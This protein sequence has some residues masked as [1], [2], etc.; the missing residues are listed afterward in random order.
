MHLIDRKRIRA[1]ID[2][3]ETSTTGHIAVRILPHL[4]SDPV[5]NAK[6]Q[7][8]EARLHHHPH[9]NSVVFVVAPQTRQ[10]AVYGDEAVHRKV[11]DEY[12]SRLVGAMTGRFKSGNLTDALVDGIEHVGEQLR[13]HFPKTESV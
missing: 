1:A 5:A 4:G 7:L 8:Q 3:V 12:W 9:R 6:L 11:G 2:S 13:L 10:F